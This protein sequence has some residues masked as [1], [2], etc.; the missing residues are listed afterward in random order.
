[1][2]LHRH[3]FMCIPMWGLSVVQGVNHTSGFK[4]GNTCVMCSNNI[5]SWESPSEVMLQRP[6]QHDLIDVVCFKRYNMCCLKLTHE[7]FSMGEGTLDGKSFSTHE[8]RFIIKFGNSSDGQ[9][10]KRSKN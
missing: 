9:K 4:R 7:L 3:R 6:G 10:Y 2:F 1:M 8:G 5:T